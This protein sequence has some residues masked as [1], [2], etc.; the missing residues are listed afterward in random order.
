MNPTLLSLSQ[1]PTAVM[2]CCAA[3]LTAAYLFRLARLPLGL[4]PEAAV[5]LPKI[6]R[7]K[8]ATLREKLLR[9][10]AVGETIVV[11]KRSLR[12]QALRR[13]CFW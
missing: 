13:I 11:A 1:D 8:K 10:F 6:T 4:E 9:F 5:K 12:G 3:V 7:N 2:E